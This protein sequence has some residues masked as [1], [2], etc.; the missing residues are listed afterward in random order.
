MLAAAG[1]YR[2][3]KDAFA[4]YET[5]LAA[6]F[7]REQLLPR[8]YDTAL[9]LAARE[10]ELGL[11]ATPWIE[12]ATHLP[13][14][15]LKGE[16]ARLLIDVADGLPWNRDR[17]GP[18]S[19]QQF[20]EQ[21]REASE[22]AREWY[23]ALSSLSP[24][25]R[26]AAYMRVAL[27]CEYRSHILDAKNFDPTSVLSAHPD[28]ALLLYRVGACG[29]DYQQQLERTFDQEPRF[30]EANYFLG[31][32]ELGSQHSDVVWRAIE[33]LRNAHEGIP[34]SP[35]LAVQLAAVYLA[36]SQ[37]ELALQ[38]YEHTLTLM[39]EHRDALLGKAMVQSYL[40]RHAEAIATATELVDLGTFHIGEAYYWRAWNKYHQQQ[41]DAARV[42]IEDAKKRW[43]HTDV[44]T[45]DGII[46]YDRKE[47][48]EARQSLDVAL[49]L[50]ARNCEAAWFLGLT[51]VGL[52]RWP[53]GGDTF[54]RA[55]SCAEGAE[56]ELKSTL[57]RIERAEMAPNIKA[58]QIAAQQ[59]SI[60]ESQQ[61][62]GT[63]AYNAA[64][65]YVKVPDLARAKP[66]LDRALQDPDMKP[67]A[68]ELLAFLNKQH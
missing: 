31:L 56:R 3:L 54:V 48:E 58:R 55:R 33:P 18:E 34:E 15:A 30:V 28:D 68:E 47:L 63:A 2:C 5:L 23:A 64:W 67:S 43:Y 42:D 49:R 50:D 46:A 10:K 13:I 9:L 26:V 4:T 22:R 29:R 53:D 36:T 37:F 1:C 61:T 12:R 11:P 25:S 52:E 57:T 65:C 45:L 24:T 6:D 40:K 41:L 19:A 35:A 66:Q 60:E 51:Y 44:F 14:G 39:P 59:K 62:Q 8:A 16:D 21:T 32:Y 38:S 7:Q 20:G 27:A 17:F